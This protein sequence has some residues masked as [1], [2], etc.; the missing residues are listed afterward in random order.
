MPLVAVSVTCWHSPFVL[1][2]RHTYCVMLSDDLSEFTVRKRLKAKL[3]SANLPV[4]GR[5]AELIGSALRQ[6]RPR[7]RR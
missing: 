4:S 7:S 5:K 2:A 1:P 3:R 6:R